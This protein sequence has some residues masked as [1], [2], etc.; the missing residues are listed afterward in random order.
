MANLA[1]F[2]KIATTGIAT[3]ELDVLSAGLSPLP[4]D[5]TA[6]RVAVLLSPALGD[7]LVT[8]IVANNL[9]RAGA[10]V[11][12]FGSQ[13]IA[14]RDWFADVPRLTIAPCALPTAPG[15]AL[16]EFDILV[17]LHQQKPVADLA[18]MHR[19]AVVLER[20]FDVRTE[21][22]MV[23]RMQAV[24]RTIFGCA[25]ATRDNGLRAPA[26]LQARRDRRRVAMHPMASTADKCW[27]PERFLALATRLRADGFSPAMI[28]AP[29]ERAEWAPRLART[30]V[31]MVEADSL[32]ALAAWIYESGWFIG[33]D[34]GIGHLASNLGVPT[35][36]LFM[37]KGIARTWRPSW[38]VGRILI[39]SEGI[40]TGKLKERL[41][42]YALTVGRVRQA[43]AALREQ[44]SDGRAGPDGN[45]VPPGDGDRDLTAATRCGDCP[46]GPIAVAMSNAIGDTLVMMVVV[47]NLLRHGIPVTVFGRTAHA[48]RQLF[49]DVDIVLPP[50]D[51]A[52][53]VAALA[54]YPTVLQMHDHQPIDGL[55]D[56]LP[57]ARTLRET[58]YGKQGG[59]MAERFEIYARKTFNLANA[60]I[61]NGLTPPKD[62]HFRLHRTRV[63]IHPE[64]ST[65]DKRW[66]NAR[67][68]R[69][70]S[71]L[72]KQGYEPYFVLAPHERARWPEL[73]ARGIAAPQFET[74]Q[75][76]AEWIYESGW[77]IGND[78]G[79]GH[80]AS[81]LG[82]P[83]LSLFRRRGS[84]QRWR[85]A[86]GRGQVALG[87]QWLP[88]ASMKEKYWRQTLHCRRVLRQFR[89]VV[90]ND[91]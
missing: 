18:S 1:I 13:T 6:Q 63:V 69:L 8:M 82:I 46:P 76:L 44:A 91:R 21:A 16:A 66:G 77:F 33:N 37:R 67:F 22:A 39:G 14:L 74:L 48:L 50:D 38:G 34:S 42:K 28:L 32:S 68:V 86:W 73:D 17:Q 49:P 64:A 36:S 78:S 51:K 3:L 71:L 10:H 27:L 80:L 59:C 31:P 9:A 81:N 90:K 2:E 65:D 11:T 89:A 7:S 52:A 70:A 4:R 30:G 53:F 87:W 62:K 25:D 19:G 56:L 85:P 60:S 43:F 88:G 84:A 41:W 24:C 40:P 47:R 83:T 5:W 12:V 55:A 15:S 79:I 54:A 75:A 61:D 45:I 20:V 26:G 29:E 72:R 57:T 58:E 23:D 35:L